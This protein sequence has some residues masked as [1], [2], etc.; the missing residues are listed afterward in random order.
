MY[1][2]R[3]SAKIHNFELYIIELKNYKKNLQDFMFS[4]EISKTQGEKIM[5]E[6]L[7]IDKEIERKSNIIANSLRLEFKQIK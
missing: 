5:S 7:S 4:Q 2:E 3:A 1:L 6:I